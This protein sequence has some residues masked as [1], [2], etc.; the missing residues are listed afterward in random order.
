MSFLFFEIILLRKRELNALLYVLAVTWMSYVPYLFL[1]VLG[2]VILLVILT[3]FLSCAS[4]RI[5]NNTYS[6]TSKFELRFFKM[7]A[8]SNAGFREYGLFMNYLKK[9]Q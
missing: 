2:S 6:K 5:V 7:L 8:Y 4:W 9:C 3:L 1:V